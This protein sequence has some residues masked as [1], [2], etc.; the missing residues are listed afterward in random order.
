MPTKGEFVHHNMNFSLAMAGDNLPEG[1][2]SGIA[3]SPTVDCYGHRVMPGAFEASIRKKGFDVGKGGIKL[4]DHHKEDGPT[5]GVIRHLKTVGENLHIE[6]ELAL[7]SNRVRDLYEETKFCGGSGFSVG[8]RLSDFEFAE[9]NGEEIF[10]IKEGD[11]REISLVNFPACP[12]ARTNVVKQETDLAAWLAEMHPALAAIKDTDTVSEL[13][14]ALA[15]KGLAHGRNEA[16]KLF[17][18]MKNC[19]HLLQDKPTHAGGTSK[20]SPHPLLDA[21]MLK[22]ALD[23]LAKVQSLL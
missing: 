21:S 23:Q 15:A 16:H 1:H 5:I 6:A 18:I 10:V 20:T 13:E 22:P 12:D 19:A 3:S 11:L 4:L 7:K 2:I 17:V 9:E 14:R 8:F